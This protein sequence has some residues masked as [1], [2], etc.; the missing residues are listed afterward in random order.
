MCSRDPSDLER[1]ARGPKQIFSPGRRRNGGV[2]GGGHA[3]VTLESAGVV[4]GEEEQD[5]P[6]SGVGGGE[7]GEVLFL[8]G[9]CALGDEVGMLE[10]I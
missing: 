6:R 1:W 3:C 7:E 10:R 5:V 8:G 4:D 9:P 2:G